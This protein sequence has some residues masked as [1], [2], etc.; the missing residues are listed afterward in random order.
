[1][2]YCVVLCCVALC[3]VVLC[4]VA[5]C[6]VVLCCVVLCCAVLCYD[7][8]PRSF[9]TELPFPRLVATVWQQQDKNMIMRIFCKTHVFVLTISILLLFLGQYSA[10]LCSTVQFSALQCS[11]CYFPYIALTKHTA[12]LEGSLRLAAVWATGS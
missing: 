6:C 4:C 10:V 7:Q 8:L 1:V 2:L 5:L 3:C 9:L 12:S 11:A